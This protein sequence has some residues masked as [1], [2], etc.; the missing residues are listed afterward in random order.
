MAPARGVSGP[1]AGCDGRAVRI[2][3]HGR[4]YVGSHVDQD[5]CRD[6]GA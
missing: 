4:R 2:E 3:T 5:A 1:D 6:E